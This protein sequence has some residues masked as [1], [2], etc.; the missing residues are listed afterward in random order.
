MST[1]L[2]LDQVKNEP[3]SLDLLFRPKSQE[4]VCF[5]YSTKSQI[6]KAPTF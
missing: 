2:L 4:F 3:K 1:K 6:S 5:L